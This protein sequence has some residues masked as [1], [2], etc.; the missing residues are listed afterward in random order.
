MAPR[1]GGRAGRMAHVE[2]VY[3]REETARLIQLVEDRLA[4]RIEDRFVAFS[5]Q[6]MQRLD[7]LTA[8]NQR[9]NRVPNRRQVREE[10]GD[11]SD[12]DDDN[13]FAGDVPMRRDREDLFA[14][15]APRGRG[16]VNFNNNNSRSWDSGCSK[17]ITE[18]SG[19]LPSDELSDWLAVTEGVLE[20]RDVPSDKRVALVTTKFRGRAAAWWQQ[21]KQ[22]RIRQGKA[23][24][25]SWEKLKKHTR[26][27]FFP[28]NYVRTLYQRLQNLKQGARSVDEY[29]TDFYQL[30]ARND[31][32]DTDDQLVSRYIGGMTLQFQ[33]S[34]NLFDPVSVSEAHSKALNL[35]KQFS[36]RSAGGNTFRG[37]LNSPNQPRGGFPNQPTVIPPRPSPSGQVNRTQPTGPGM[38]PRGQG[39]GSS[40]RCFTCGETGHR[41]A[42]CRKNDKYGKG[43]F[44]EGEEISE[45]QRHDFGDPVYDDNDEVQEEFVEGDTG[46][47]LVV[48]RACFASREADGDEW[49]RNNVFQSTCT[50][51]GKVCHLVIDPGSCENV[52]SEEVVTKLALPTEQHPKPYRLSWLKKGNILTVT[53]RCLVP[54]SIGSKYKDKAW[55]DVV[56]MDVCHLLLGR[57]WEFDRYVSHDGQKN[58]YSFMLDTGIITLVPSK[59]VASK[60]PT[61]GENVTLLTKQ[62]FVEEAAETGIVYVLNGTSSPTESVVPDVVKPLIE[63][64]SDVFPADLPEGLPLLRDIQHQIDLVPGSRLP[65]RPHYRMSPK[66]HEDL[67]RQVEELLV[68]GFVRASLSPCAVPALLTP[69]KDGTWRICVDS[70]AINKITVRYSHPIP[71][72]DDLMDQLSGAQFFTKLDLKS[73]Y[74]QIRV[75][76][77]DEWKTA[78]KTR[79]GLFEWLVMPFGLSNAPSTF[80]RF[81]NQVLRPFIGK[82]VVVYFDDI[83]IYSAT[84]ELH[85]QHLQ[86]V[87]TVLRREQLFA[88]VSKCEFMTDS[89]LFLGYVVSKDGI[90]MDANKV[91]AIRDW[92]VPTTLFAVRSF[93]GLASFYRRFI[94]N[95]SSIMAPITDCMK[96]GR[97]MWTEQATEAFALIK[98]KL[99]T[100]P[101]LVLPDF[102]QPFELHCDA[103]KVGVGGVLTQHGRPVAF[104]SE[105]LNGSKLNYNTYD[106]EFYAIIQ[107]LKHWRAYLI[108]RP[109]VLYSDHAALK[110]INNQDKLSDRHAEWASYLQ[111]FTFVVKHKAGILNKVADALSRRTSLLTLMRT[112]VLG[113]YSFAE[114]YASDPFFPAF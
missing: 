91:A 77:G 83:L 107:A 44:V 8:A 92:P 47:M 18:F 112:K 25:N 60:K 98:E 97:F 56:D 63:E 57:P 88:A 14:E 9:Q 4:Q 79:E 64:F 75:R 27:A 22:T 2:D 109:F 3:E 103:S 6:M 93:H 94:H 55:C 35:E 108:Y 89:V 113:F 73:G 59:E 42:D 50:I 26:A 96:A 7:V 76:P 17:E 99:T 10:E 15:D 24:I 71:R 66:E 51:G 36:R 95:F 11:D 21:L 80:M 102:S 61:T 101:V 69:K 32:A 90:S 65:N 62:Q 16:R 53:K 23:K 28:Y 19:N 111:E 46:P 1:G 38:V 72:F 68:K 34:L 84:P 85:L 5:E 37:S 52:V 70:R 29:T 82:F 45:H 39:A 41:M 104:F 30:V 48:H 78:F 105:K 58:T 87:L 114:L 110:H 74:H 12:A 67:R 20:L 40:A 106:V 49:L 81:M 31:L 33:E 86:E 100:A 13:P 43:L 54:I